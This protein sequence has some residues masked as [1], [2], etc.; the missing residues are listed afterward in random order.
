MKLAYECIL[1]AVASVLLALLF[2]KGKA[3]PK[4]GSVKAGSP[5]RVSC[6]SFLCIPAH[7]DGLGNDSQDHWF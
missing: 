3:D 6:R 5:W 2:M 1:Y 4:E 7:R